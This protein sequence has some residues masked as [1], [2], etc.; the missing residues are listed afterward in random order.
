MHQW[1]CHRPTRQVPCTGSDLLCC[2]TSL[3]SDLPVVVACGA[4]SCVL[5]LCVAHHHQPQPAPAC[6]RVGTATRLTRC[7]GLTLAPQMLPGSAVTWYPMHADCR[8]PLQWLGGELHAAV[9]AADRAQQ[10]E[11]ARCHALLMCRPAQ[12]SIRAAMYML[13]LKYSS[14]STLNECGPKAQ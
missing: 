9:G 4:L 12:H 13:I 10:H 8:P 3:S 2:L 5:A 11:R 6:A 14:A 1:P 7:N